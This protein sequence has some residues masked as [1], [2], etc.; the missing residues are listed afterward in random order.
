MMAS[1][2]LQALDH[3]VLY[4][5]LFHSPNLR[6][7]YSLILTHPNIYS[8]FDQ[9]RRLILRSV[10]RAQI[11]APPLAQLAE[12]HALINKRQ[13]S[14]VTDRIGLLEAIWYFFRTERAITARTRIAWAT[15]LLHAYRQAH[16]VQEALTFARAIMDDLLMHESLKPNLEQ[17]TF[18]RSVVR[19]YS[20]ERLFEDEVALQMRMR[21]REEIK[22]PHFDIWSKELAMT[23]RST[24]NLESILTYQVG[25]WELYANRLGG[26]HP[27]TLNWA[28]DHVKELQGA[29]QEG[30]ALDFHARARRSINTSSPERFAWS[31]QL[32]RLYERAGRHEDALAVMNDVWQRMTPADKGYRAW[33][34]DMC[35]LLLSM[36]RPE[37]ATRVCERAWSEINQRLARSPRDKYWQYLAH[38]AG[39]A[40][41]K[42]YKKEGRSNEA[43]N[44]E[45]QCKEWE[46]SWQRTSRAGKPASQ[47]V[48]EVMRI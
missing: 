5:I 17:R 47:S 19:L 18:A 21:D 46:R 29:S 22:S 41:A 26:G 35:S 12:V 34:A 15:D 13:I 27:T 45:A 43:V 44:V 48:I 31:R 24:G 16:L 30:A 4:N 42:M 7:L 9:H 20:A 40:L 37:E 10:F 36:N 32:T 38:G 14:S 1:P 25:T 33:A 3:D 6:T 11:K 23:Y 2:T 28:R 8:T 39:L